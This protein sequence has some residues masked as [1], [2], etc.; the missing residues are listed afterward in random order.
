MELYMKLIATVI[1]T[2]LVTNSLLY[3]F[4]PTQK[5]KTKINFSASCWSRIFF[6]SVYSKQPS[7]SK[8][9]RIQQTF[10]K[11]FSCML[12]MFTLQSRVCM[13]G[14]Y[15]LIFFLG[16]SILNIMQIDFFVWRKNFFF[17][18]KKGFLD[19]KDFDFLNKFPPQFN[20]FLQ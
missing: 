19:K 14:T 6:F 20:I 15:N 11:E 9:C 10:K 5:P 1:L 3:F 18:M 2:N 16:A 13:H 17:L 4:V 8:P 12:F 7:V